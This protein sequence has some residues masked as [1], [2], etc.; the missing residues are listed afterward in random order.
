MFAKWW[1]FTKKKISIISL[2]FI[3]KFQKNW[4]RFIVIS[5]IEFKNFQINLM[6]EIFMCLMLEFKKLFENFFSLRITFFLK[7]NLSQ[8][9]DFF[10]LTFFLEFALFF[11]YFPNM[12]CQVRKI[13]NQKHVLVVGGGRG[14]GG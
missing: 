4:I 11:P 12:N 9:F 10:F 6:L 2:I 5:K 1:K 13:K 8:F 7:R 14:T 3:S